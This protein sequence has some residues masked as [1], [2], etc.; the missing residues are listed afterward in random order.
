MSKESTGMPEELF[1][2]CRLI[3]HGAATSAGAIGAAPIP[4][5]DTIPIT[6]V[7]AGMIMALGKVFDITIGKALA[8]EILTLGM[9]V[10]AGRAVFTG[11]LKCIPGAGTIIG[12]ALGA[13]TAFGMTELLGW[14]VA[15]DFYKISIGEKPEKLREDI[16]KKIWEIA[17]ATVVTI[18]RPP[19]TGP[20]LPL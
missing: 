11:I 7:Q 5:A 20:H 1:E 3:I 13:G 2:K 9:T 12:G 19:W 6:G 17:K 10:V 4:F 8:E 14:T 18:P 16:A 15:K